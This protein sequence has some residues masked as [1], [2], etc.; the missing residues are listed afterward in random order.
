MERKNNDSLSSQMKRRVSN[1]DRE[2]EQYDGNFEDVVTTGSTLLDLAISGRRVRGGGLPSG[3]VVEAFGPSQSGKTVLL[4]QI[5]G[6]IQRRGGD[7][8]FHDPEA[9]LDQEFS[10]LFG[11]HIPKD[12]YFVPDTITEV[13]KE[14]RTWKPNPG[15]ASAVNGIFADSLAA[16]STNMEMEEEEG[17][18]MGMRR[19]KEFSEQL[20]K[21]C[22]IIRKNNYLMVCSNQVR[23][24]PEAQK[25]QQKFTA[26]GGKAFEFY[27]T[28]RLRFGSPEKIYQSIKIHGKEVKKVIGITVEIEVIKTADVP[29]RK[30]ELS[31][32]YGYGIDDI[33]ANLQYIKDFT[34]NTVYSVGDIEL[35]NSLETAIKKVEDQG[36]EKELREQ[37]IDLW[38]EIDSK[39]KTERKPRMR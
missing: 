7:L 31:I 28:V 9:R 39:F 20:R 1:K 14:V 13:F 29:Y 6:E 17:D 16:L 34:K 38:E 22:R 11:M 3:I 21:N 23:V 5:A 32:I 27:S 26:P 37:V 36:L 8:Q 30:A 18:K 10:S 33:R 24:N 25:Y 12:K 19:A 4:S 35:S 15:K 2:E